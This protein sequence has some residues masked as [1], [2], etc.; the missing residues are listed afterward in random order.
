MELVNKSHRA[1]RTF[2]DVMLPILEIAVAG[3]K[4][5]PDVEGFAMEISYHIR[6][7]TMGMH[8]EHPENLVLVLPKAAAVRLVS[9]KNETDRQAALLDGQFFFNGEPFILYLSDRAAEAA[10]KQQEPSA[11]AVTSRAG[12]PPAVSASA[13]NVLPARPAAAPAAP[14]RGTSPEALAKIQSS[15]Q[16]MIDVVVKGTGLAGPFCV[17]CAAGRGGIQQERLP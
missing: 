2:Q 16:K 1:L 8:M 13:G 12:D 9:A 17:V 11:P 6:G 7:Q 5:N 14:L 4:D 15:D 3:L 10:A